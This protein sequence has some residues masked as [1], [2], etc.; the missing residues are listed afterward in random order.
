MDKILNRKEMPDTAKCN[1]RYC[2]QYGFGRCFSANRLKSRWLLNSVCSS[3][4]GLD[5]SS[6]ENSEGVGK[7]A[8]TLR[9]I[10]GLCECFFFGSSLLEGCAADLFLWS[11]VPVH[12]IYDVLPIDKQKGAKNRENYHF[13][14]VFGFL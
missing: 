14:G 9:L 3:A 12:H 5:V 13:V 1:L 6:V 10:V 4:W 11:F 2:C 7:I 8:I